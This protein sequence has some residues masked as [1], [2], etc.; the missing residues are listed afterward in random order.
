M[1]LDSVASLVQQLQQHRLL[2]PKQL[3]ELSATMQAQFPDVRLLLRELCKRDWLTA[4]Q[5]NHV[6][7]GAGKDL[8][9]GKYVLLSK[10]GEGPMGQDFKA[11]HRLMNRLVALKLIRPELLARPEAVQKFYEDTQSASQLDHK[12]IVHA[13][14][15]GPVGQTHFFAMEYVEGIDLDKLVTSAGPP[16]LPLTC[17]FLRQT[18]LG[19]QHAH[20]MGILHQ[21]LRPA[22]LLVSRSA[23]VAAGA[24][25]S[26]SWRS[27]M[28]SDAVVKIQNLGLTL[29]RTAHARDAAAVDYIAPERTQPGNKPDARCDQIGRAHV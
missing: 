4:Y 28:G 1:P 14:D 22:N 16:P 26:D 27:L 21:D 3:D 15:A 8:V 13:Y 17:E 11:K 9:L 25:P 7:Q 20:E 5:A 12:N 10:V 23:N 6:F 2:E 29:L 19:L 18:A 24:S